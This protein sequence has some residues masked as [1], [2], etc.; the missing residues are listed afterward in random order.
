MRALPRTRLAC[1]CLAAIVLCADL[2]NAS[3]ANAAGLVVGNG[4]AASCTAGA[5]AGA[6]AIGGEISF[7]CGDAP[8]T[9]TVTNELVIA[10]D[11]T[12]TG[13][14]KITLRGNGATRVLRSVDGVFD[15]TSVKSRLSVTISGIIV[16]NGSTTDQG[17]GM[18]VGF[19]NSFTLRDS[20]F[21]NNR[22][23]KDS[24]QCDGGGALFIGGGS[25]AAIER[26]AFA[27][28]RANNGGAINSLRTNLSIV[29]STFTNN[30]ATH[31][32]KINTFGDCGGGGGVYI[33][34]ARQPESGGPA[35]MT[36]S[37]STFVGNGTNNHGAGLFVGLYTNESLAIDATL[38]DG[39]VTTKATSY[40]GSGTGGAIWY[41]SATGSAN[42]ATFSLSNSALLNNKAVGQGG[43]L[44]TSAPAAISN[45]SFYRNDAT[46]ASITN[47][48]DYRRG[49]GGAL[50]VNN[51]AAVTIL[52]STFAENRAGF[53]GGAIAGK[54][55]TLK[56]TLFANNTADWPIKIMQH[57]TDALSDGGNNMQ[58]PAK[59]PNPNYYNETNCTQSIT[60]ADPKLL[61]PADN[62]GATPTLA[63]SADSPATGAGN[64]ATCTATDQRGV[65]RTADG[66]CD[67]GAYELVA[68][69]TGISPA[70][71]RVN[72]P[73]VTLTVSGAGFIAST[74]V[75]LN[76]EELPTEFIN[77]TTLRTTVPAA[78][79][80]APGTLQVGVSGSTLPT[81]P[82]QVAANV[83]SAYLPLVRR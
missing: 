41:G 26:S 57:C 78:S 15:G 22:A 77:S 18:R 83:S 65:S 3:R 45:T 82:L 59:N 64:P 53:N 30:Q 44:W 31:S 34:G 48:D 9:I 7:S 36:I 19:W 79:L 38:F 37:R 47:P 27:N 63:L 33:D 61:P 49:N 76:G 40:D 28:N 13:G 56:N 23:T 43:G 6:L 21:T 52:N 14:G 4:T 54:T 74:K 62:G 39:N 51:N 80:R 5:L 24:A 73:G 58:F 12:L 55:I 42:N 72:T 32:D 11:T 16:D 35:P 68:G 71:V 17:G 8:A 20:S 46:D 75:L 1:L 50:A 10:K 67:L 60:I 25:T 66:K 69:I 2:R 29:D 81:R 70:L